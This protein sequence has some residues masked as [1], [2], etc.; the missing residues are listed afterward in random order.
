[1]PKIKALHFLQQES[2]QQ[3]DF[4]EKVDFIFDK[5]LA[6][7]L[8]TLFYADGGNGKSWLAFALAKHCVQRGLNTVYCDFD[9]PLSV[10]KERHIDK[11]LIQAHHDLNYIQRGKCQLSPQDLLQ[12]LDEQAIGNAFDHYVFFIDSL[13]NFCNVNNEQ[14]SM[15]TMDTLMN[16]REAGATIIILHH[17]N[18]DGK[19]YQGSNNIRNSV[20]NM[21]QLVKLNNAQANQDEIRLHL[22]VKK[23]RANIHDAAYLINTR[24][25]GITAIDEE[26]ATL[27]TAKEAFVQ[28]VLATLKEGKAN[29]TQ[30]LQA[31]N[32]SKDDKTARHWLDEFDGKYWQSEKVSGVFQYQ[33]LA[34]PEMLKSTTDTTL[35]PLA[36]NH[37]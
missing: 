10:L 36:E 1:M 9:N 34:T 20:D 23:E 33:K 31:A 14:Q 17:S 25:L 21:Y 8:I 18:K 13:R 29:K 2:L 28:A 22:K 32:K 27:G 5:V 15:S 26:T 19:N 7:R 30:L 4:N 3:H 12:K 16:L 35:Q 6:K 24:T 37:G 11:N